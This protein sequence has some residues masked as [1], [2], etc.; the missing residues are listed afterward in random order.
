M[1]RIIILNDSIWLLIRAQTKKKQTR[2]FL[3][4]WIMFLIF[5][6]SLLEIQW[7]RLAYNVF[8]FTNIKGKNLHITSRGKNYIFYLAKGREN[9]DFKKYLLASWVGGIRLF[10]IYLS[11]AT[12]NRSAEPCSKYWPNPK[13]QHV[14]LYDQDKANF[15]VARRGYG[16]DLEVILYHLMSLLEVWGTRGS[17]Q[18][19]EIPLSSGPV[20]WRDRP[21]YCFCVNHLPLS[22]AFCH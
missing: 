13:K 10:F 11:I 7:D 15:A 6:G 8:L 21:R 17:F 12:I 4:S 20:R 1:R 22:C 18:G 14:L 5:V 9:S 3:S 19:K 16:W 2:I